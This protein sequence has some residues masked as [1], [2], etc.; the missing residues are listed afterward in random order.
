MV[1]NAQAQV[2]DSIQTNLDT[3][4]IK[5]DNFMDLQAEMVTGL[6]GTEL[7]GK[8]NGKTLNF[9]QLLEK[10]DLPPEQKIE[11]RNWY[12][13]QAKDLSQKQKDSLGNAIAQK[14]KAAQSESKQR[15]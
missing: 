9:L 10:T 14:I 12:Y 7:D 11:L 8:S 15:P 5:K 3:T 4:K 1:I 6:F 2:K 13:L